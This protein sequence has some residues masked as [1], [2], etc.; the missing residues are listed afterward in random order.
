MYRLLGPGVLNS[1]ADSASPATDHSPHQRKEGTFHKRDSFPGFKETR[2]GQWTF[3]AQAAFQVTLI[4]SN[5]HARVGYLGSLPWETYRGDGGGKNER[6]DVVGRTAGE[7]QS[8]CGPRTA[9][10]SVMVYRVSAVS[11]PPNSDRTRVKEI[12]TL[13]Y[14]EAPW[15]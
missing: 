5:Q 6:N 15:F 11:R 7:A 12:S 8:H 2:E 4:Q 14:T 9:G 10:F 3:L 1:S 13:T